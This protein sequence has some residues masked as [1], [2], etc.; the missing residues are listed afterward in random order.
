MGRKESIQK[1]KWEILEAISNESGDLRQKSYQCT[2][3]NFTF[4]RQNGNIQ[5]PMYRKRTEKGKK[6]IN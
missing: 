2:W 4:L 6:K 3:Y 1:K 5:I